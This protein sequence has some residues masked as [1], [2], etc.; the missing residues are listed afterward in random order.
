MDTQVGMKRARG[1]GRSGFVTVL[2]ALMT[3]LVSGCI[4]LGP[5]HVDPE[6]LPGVYRNEDTGA[7]IRLGADGRF[8]A[9]GLSQD[10]VEIDGGTAALDDFGGTWNPTPSNFVYLEPERDGISDIQLWTVSSEKVYL[11]PNVEG[12]ISLILVRVE[13][14]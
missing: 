4:G 1:A 10:D 6:A 3:V 2:V 14:S 12:P 13:G 9:I 5:G 8:S 7:E 11:H